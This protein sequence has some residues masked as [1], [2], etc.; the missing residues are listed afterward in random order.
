MRNLKKKK[1]KSNTKEDTQ[2][3][4]SIPRRV[5]AKCCI[6]SLSNKQSINKIIEVTS[7][8]EN[9]KVSFKNFSHDVV[10]ALK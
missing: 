7:S 2:F 9:K 5:V 1:Q 3:K 4:G 6:D 8:S 10:L